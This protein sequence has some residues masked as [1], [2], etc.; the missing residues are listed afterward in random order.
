M[1]TKNNYIRIKAKGLLPI[2]EEKVLAKIALKNGNLWEKEYYQSDQIENIINDFRED[3]KE[4]I[5]EEYIKDWKNKK[6]SLKMD[7][8]IKTLI[9]KEIPSLNINDKNIKKSLIFEEEEKIPDIIGK[10]LND[11]FEIFT[12]CKKDKLLKIQKYDKEIIEKMNLNDI[13]SFY[14]YCNGNNYL[15]LSGGENKNLEI[16]QKF[17]K[18]NLETQAINCLD[19]IPKKN[20][21]MIYI[22]G[23]YVFIVGGNDVKT[24]YYDLIANEFTEWGDLNKKR[25]EPSLALINNEL[26]CFDNSS[27]K[28][29]NESFTLEK[30]GLTS[31]KAEWIIINPILNSPAINQKFFGVIKNDDNNIL[32]IGGNM[33]EEENNNNFNYKYN[34]YLNTIGETD[35]PFKEFNL[36][37]KT[38]LPYNENIYYIIPDFNRHHPEIIFYQ[39]NKKKIN[40]VKYEPNHQNHNQ[41]MINNNNINSNIDYKKNYNLNMP[42][43]SVLKKEINNNNNEEKYNLNINEQKI[44]IKEPSFPDINFNSEN[45]KQID[46]NPPFKAPEM[47]ACNQD[48][49]ISINVPFDNSKQDL[50]IIYP[51]N[52][53]KNENNE[54]NQNKRNDINTN[55]NIKNAENNDI[56]NNE[57]NE[58]INKLNKSNNNLEYNN[59]I[60]DNLEKEL[61]NNKN[62]KNDIYNDNIIFNEEIK[63]KNDE[64]KKN[65]NISP[66]FNIN[67]K[68]KKTQ[69]DKSTILENNNKNSN[70]NDPNIRENINDKNNIYNHQGTDNNPLN[71]KKDSKLNNNRNINN[72]EAKPREKEID[73]KNN[74]SRPREILLK[75]TIPGINSKDVKTETKS[76]RIDINRAKTPD[77]TNKNFKDNN[78]I[79]FKKDINIY[80]VIYGC[81][82]KEIKNPIPN[83]NRGLNVKNGN[84]T[85]I[86]GNKENYNKG[87]YNNS[88]N[89]RK[90]I[91]QSNY[92]KN[93][94]KQQIVNNT[95]NPSGININFPKYNLPYTGP[96]IN[97]NPNNNKNNIVIGDNL[98]NK[99]KESEQQIGEINNYNI[100]LKNNNVDNVDI[101]IKNPNIN[102]NEDNKEFKIKIESQKNDSKIPNLE[103]NNLNNNKNRNLNTKNEIKTEIKTS[104]MT[105][106]LK[107]NVPNYHYHLVGIIKG[108]KDYKKNNRSEIKENKGGKN[109]NRS[110][111]EIKPKN[112]NI[113]NANIKSNF[114]KNI[115]GNNT[116]KNSKINNPS[117]NANIE[118][119]IELKNLKKIESNNPEIKDSNSAVNIK[120]YITYNPYKK[121]PDSKIN[122][123]IPG[124]TINNL[125]D[126]NKKITT[127]EQDTYYNGEFNLLKNNIE[128]KEGN[129]IGGE[130]N[131]NNNN[132]I[133]LIIENNNNEKNNSFDMN[134]NI[135]VGNKKDNINLNNLGD[136][137]MFDEMN[138]NIENN[139]NDVNIMISGNGELKNIKKKGL[140]IVGSKNTNFKPSKKEEVGNLD[141]N[142]INIDN[143]KSSNV[144]INGSTM[145]DR[146]I[147]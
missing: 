111:T 35:I 120:S 12:F 137:Y 29:N 121:S 108:S 54:E 34:I 36:K 146:I 4:E 43:I 61:E 27:F 134:I 48:L 26:Y 33:N 28:N 76:I 129:N 38:F 88:I 59:K 90:G 117:D 22:P 18:I 133:N 7:E 102:L 96:A 52:D 80:G 139:N 42:S 23:N 107:E 113:N 70:L 114:N 89:N 20:H 66:D 51:N 141:V 68:G 60:K 69:F 25:I 78:E 86:D 73:Y 62:N 24:I 53:E 147:K 131:I 47:N 13:D 99:V 112:G 8:K 1:N 5:P 91:N 46:Q 2:N 39:K 115:Q 144:R 58:E 11:P 145:G 6:Q 92:P 10:P 104:N 109:I 82:K 9:I 103:E 128:I 127:K 98:N 124:N 100:N 15:F 41:K 116:F 84:R 14:A 49:K 32:F 74:Y 105:N 110:K 118:K 50:N 17:W 55:I 85:K 122:E 106:N 45:K 44:E 93:N 119:E 77:F 40:V 101:N 126:L 71:N 65:N 135:D 21:S 140:P 3:N 143:L 125:N 130:I 19:M 94:L 56:N 136:N 16:I 132:P 67:L 81:K 72:K 64:N 87:N 83:K 79:D 31:E 75:G 57:L 63:E 142:S 30:T 95:G 138:G 123:N 37:E 97:N